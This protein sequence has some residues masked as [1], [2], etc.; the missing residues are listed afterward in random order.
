MLTSSSCHSADSAETKPN[1]GDQG[2]EELI[3]RST[4]LVEFVRRTMPATLR[5]FVGASD[6]VQS[7]WLK[8]NQNRTKFENLDEL[9]FRS[10][11]VCIASR[12]IVDRLRSF[13]LTERTR[14][15]SMH[16]VPAHSR[17]C[18]VAAEPEPLQLALLHEQADR[19]IGA[20]AKLPLETQQIMTLRYSDGLTFQQIAV[21]LNIP[22]STCRRRWQEGCE[23]LRKL[24]A[25]VF[26]EYS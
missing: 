21:Q 26:G 7:I 24:L 25:D 11:V 3:A 17:N 23:L 18:E 9:Q 10:S 12:K 20:I 6:I 19:L 22:V 8:V 5:R 1:C 4:F 14:Q 15:R 2:I 16:L 13:H